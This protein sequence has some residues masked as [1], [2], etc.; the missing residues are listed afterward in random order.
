MKNKQPNATDMERPVDRTG[1]RY[2]VRTD[3]GARYIYPLD[4][5]PEIL[6]RVSKEGFANRFEISKQLVVFQDS[7][8]R[9][10]YIGGTEERT[11]VVPVAKVLPTLKTSLEALQHALW[12]WR[13]LLDHCESAGLGPSEWLWALQ[14]T[15]AG[16]SERVTKMEK[17][18]AELE[19][20]AAATTEG[21]F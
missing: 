1:Y 4:Q 19:Q 3:K 9:D 7:S 11:S 15:V 10:Y 17:L 14:R 8:T 6:R 13:V 21:V 16:S 2:E 20:E 5:L 18:V 12:C